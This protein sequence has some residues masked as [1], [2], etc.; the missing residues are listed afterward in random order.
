MRTL[1][2]LCALVGVASAQPVD[3]DTEAARRHFDKGRALYEAGKYDEAIGEFE[4]A[5]KL[6]PLPDL[7]FNIARTH[8]RR[9]AWGDAAAAY[10]RYL[11][12]KP[13]AP[14]AAEL[15][16]RIE[17]LRSR[18]SV[19]IVA[20]PSPSPPP[21]PHRSR[22]RGL[23]GAAIALAVGA[24]MMVVAGAAVISTVSNEYELLES[25]C[26]FRQCVPQDWAG[27]PDRA[28]ASY[29]L[30]GLAGAFAVTDVVLWVVDWRTGAPVERA[31]MPS[32]FLAP[33]GGGEGRGGSLQVRF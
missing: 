15:R 30:F 13:D 25:R 5:R 28:N 20:A 4:V 27:L 19:P 23:R 10:Q 1:M 32:P 8:E 22:S 24:V 33:P 21:P 14:D 11:D 9:E 29:A 17:V 3:P 31:A 6:K 7:D 26:S 18:V 16:A 12:A 2:V